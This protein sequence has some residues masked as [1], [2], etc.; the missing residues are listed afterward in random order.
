MLFN[1]RRDFSAHTTFSGLLRNRNKFLACLDAVPQRL[2]GLV[3]SLR[4]SL[5]L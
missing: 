1:Y 2:G 5:T 3:S 4:F